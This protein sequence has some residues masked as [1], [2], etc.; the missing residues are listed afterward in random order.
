[1]PT[2]G[3]TAQV[4]AKINNTDYNTQWVTPIQIATQADMEAA[5]DNTKAVSPLVVK[6]NPGV[7]KAIVSFVGSTGA[8]VSSFGVSSV[9]RNSAGTYTITFSTNFSSVNYWPVFGVLQKVA[10]AIAGYMGGYG[11][12]T[13]STCVVTT[14][15]TNA[16][17]AWLAADLDEVTV[18][19]FGDQ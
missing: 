10:G 5:T 7:A 17:G 18:A 1:V 11:T 8:I 6:N 4:L 13:V 16:S 2:G 9:V 14:N 15:S 19:F 12:K 3:T